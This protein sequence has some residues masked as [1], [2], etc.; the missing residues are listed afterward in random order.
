LRFAGF[1]AQIQAQIRAQIQGCAEW[2]RV[3]RLLP[4]LCAD[5][6]LR[7]SESRQ[8]PLAPFLLPYFPFPSLPHQR[9]AHLLQENGK[10]A[11]DGI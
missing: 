1:A 9:R 5:L 8:R 4:P 11:S 7:R 2:R 3:L 6:P 10:E